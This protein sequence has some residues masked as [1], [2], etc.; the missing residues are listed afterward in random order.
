[1]HGD[2][3]SL[4]HLARD[5]L[6]C[7]RDC[8][9]DNPPRKIAFLGQGDFSTAF[10]LDGHLVAR[11][12]RHADADEALRREASLLPHLARLVP[13]AIPLPVLLPRR[14]RG[15]HVIALHEQIRGSELRPELWRALAADARSRCAR[16]LGDVLTCLHQVDP[17]S[18][19]SWG[20]LPLDH[21]EEARVARERIR[22]LSNAVLPDRLRR[23]TDEVLARY[24]VGGERWSFQ[25]ALAHADLSPDHV[26]F[27]AAEARL[28]GVIDW[29][30]AGI[31]DPAR[32]F[33][34]LYEDWGSAFLGAVLE[35]YALEPPARLLPRIHMHFVI[36]QVDWII[37][38][39]RC[40]DGTRL[41]AAVAALERALD[42]LDLELAQG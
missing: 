1:M 12:A 9:P 33:V 36:V 31:G 41:D 15:G 32:D 19:R 21:V 4:K 42:E 35:R 29:G 39:W 23:R 37:D 10:L 14:A 18:A 16:E 34:Y 5:V 30:D 8:V 17:D 3:S 40:E 24:E 26:F 7:V 20:A 28:A 25:P 38:A 11:L 13:L 27:D 6:A 2:S 22:S